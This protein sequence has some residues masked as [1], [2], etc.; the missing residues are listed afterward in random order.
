MTRKENKFCVDCGQKGVAERRRCKECALEYNRQRARKRH[1]EKGRYNYGKGVCAICKKEMILWR[2]DQLTHSNYRRKT[3]DNYNNVS[4]SNKENTTGRQTVLDLGIRIPKGWVV[5]HLDENPENNEIQN[6]IVMSRSDH[7]SLHR[8]L[9]LN[10][11]LWLKNHSSNS[12]NCWDTLRDRLTTAW[13]E[14]TS[15]NVIR[16]DD[17]GQSAAEP[18]SPKGYEEGSEAMHGGSKSLD[19]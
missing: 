14:T 4:R 5:H 8:Y 10:W 19:G 3:V 2:K 13:L 18:L 11:S 1:I 9:Q 7:C 16:I 17:I 12:E 6:L 15:A